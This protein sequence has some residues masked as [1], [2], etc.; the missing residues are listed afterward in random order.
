M[1]LL[2]LIKYHRLRKADHH[3]LINH[4]IRLL[5]EETKNRGNDDDDGPIE[6][7]EYEDDTENLADYVEK[8]TKEEAGSY[9]SS[10]G[11]RSPFPKYQSADIPPPSSSSFGQDPYKYRREKFNQFDN[12]Y[13]KSFI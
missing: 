13:S 9:G 12:M 6:E 2:K 7:E 10:R 5:S 4:S 3:F 11:I 1:L 8:Q